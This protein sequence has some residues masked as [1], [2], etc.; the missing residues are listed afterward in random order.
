MFSPGECILQQFP[1]LGWN[2][3]SG[4]TQRVSGNLFK[5]MD[6][7]WQGFNPGERSLDKYKVRFILLKNIF[8]K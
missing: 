8:I 2:Q 7:I 3:P 5:F 4:E 6:T 1:G